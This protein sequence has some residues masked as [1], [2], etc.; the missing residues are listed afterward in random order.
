MQTAG[1]YKRPFTCTSRMTFYSLIFASPSRVKYAHAKGLRCTAQS[2][3]FAAGQFGNILSL[4]AACELG[5]EYSVATMLGAAESNQL[6]VVQFL[7]GQAC[8]WDQTV[9]HA[10]A[11]RGDLEMLQWAHEHGCPVDV[12]TILRIAAS[13]GHI[14]MVA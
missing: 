13:S 3:K 6:P 4:M 7:H 5:M 1:I 14:E 9:S 8:P 11:R 10:A 12:D 2:Y